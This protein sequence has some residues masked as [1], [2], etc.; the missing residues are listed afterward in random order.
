MIVKPAPHTKLLTISVPLFGA[1]GY[2]RS[3]AQERLLLKLQ[4]QLKLL[5]VDE[6]A[7]VPLSQS[8]AELLLEIF[9]QRHE[10]LY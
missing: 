9:S 10:L 5:V 3:K 4:A 7:Y 1:A 6:L 8:G 2:V